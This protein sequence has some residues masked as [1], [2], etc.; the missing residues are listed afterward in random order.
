MC[1]RCAAS[2]TTRRALAVNHR[3]QL[4]PVTQPNSV[5]QLAGNPRPFDLGL[6]RRLRHSPDRVT[7]APPTPSRGHT[8]AL[9]VIAKIRLRAFSWQLRWWA[10]NYLKEV[11]P[12]H[13]ISPLLE[14]VLRAADALPMFTYHSARRPSETAV[15]RC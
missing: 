8:T 3:P 6:S 11:S 4:R 1:H 5:A 10:G 12:I 15:Y 9:L 7:P 2:Q 14:A 13:R